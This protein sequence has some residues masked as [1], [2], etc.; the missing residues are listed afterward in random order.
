[1][2]K[3]VQFEFRICS[4]SFSNFRHH[5]IDN[6]S[7]VLVVLSDWFNSEFVRHACGYFPVNIGFTAS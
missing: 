2:A 3:C 5:D 1:M 4:V 6:T 7:L